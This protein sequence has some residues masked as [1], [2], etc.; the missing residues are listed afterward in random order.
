MTP[1]DGLRCRFIIKCNANYQPCGRPQPYGPWG[2][3]LK[4]LVV[5]V[6]SPRRSQVLARQRLDAPHASYLRVYL[7][8]CSVFPL[9]QGVWCSG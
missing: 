3:F 2:H 9:P 8:S 5:K 1:A 4:Q 6:L 7:P